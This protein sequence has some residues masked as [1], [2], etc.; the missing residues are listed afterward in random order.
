MMTGYEP[1]DIT[2]KAILV[3]FWDMN[4]RPS[5]NCIRQLAKQAHQL[6]LRNVAIVTVQTSK[7]DEGTLSEWVKKNSIPFPVGM[8]R[9]D[10]QQARST[11]GVQSLPWLILTD[12]T[13][14]VFAE[15]FPVAELDKQVGQ[16]GDK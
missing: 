1:K 16:L 2:G 9:G 7:V 13:Q 10:E 12:R 15:G 6:K 3:C 4:Q 8:V 11:W 14:I 5:R